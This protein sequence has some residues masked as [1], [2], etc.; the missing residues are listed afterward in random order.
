MYGIEKLEDFEN[1]AVEKWM[2]LG[3]T[4]PNITYWKDFEIPSRIHYVTVALKPY[5]EQD[6]QYLSAMGQP[7]SVKEIIFNSELYLSLIR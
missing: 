1:R 5:K 4:K 2:T 6:T 3:E 7:A